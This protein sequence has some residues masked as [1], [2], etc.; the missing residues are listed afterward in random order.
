MKPSMSCASSGHITKL[1]Q[2]S[3]L[4]LRLSIYIWLQLIYSRERT[5]VALILEDKLYNTLTSI[6]VKI[7]GEGFQLEIERGKQLIL[8]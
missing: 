3:N 7:I 1:K 2:S 6:Q 4:F 5:K 8:N